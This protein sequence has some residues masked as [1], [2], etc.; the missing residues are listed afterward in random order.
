M[1]VGLNRSLSNSANSTNVLDGSV[2]KDMK[3]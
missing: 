2:L 3:G 1:K